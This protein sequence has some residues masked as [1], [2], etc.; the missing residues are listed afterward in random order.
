LNEVILILDIQNSP[1]VN[2]NDKGTNMVSKDEAMNAVANQE[3]FNLECHVVKT[4]I[5]AIRGE[6]FNP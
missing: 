6:D 5:R 3:C 1:F 4:S 2:D